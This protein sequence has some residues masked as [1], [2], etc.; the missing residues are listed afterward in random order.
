LRTV[1]LLFL[2]VVIAVIPSAESVHTSS[3]PESIIVVDRFDKPIPAGESLPD[4]YEYR[5]HSNVNP[6]IYTIVPY[7][8]ASD[9]EPPAYP[10]DCVLKAE[11]DSGASLIGKEL[12]VDLNEYPILTWKWKI[13]KIIAKGDAQKKERHDFPA[14]IYVAVKPKGGFNPFASIARTVAKTVKGIPIPK[15]TINLIWSSKYEAGQV[16]TSPWSDTN[17]CVV[18]E[19]GPEHAGQWIEN[20][21]NLL[22]EYNRIFPGGPAEVE[23]V[24]IMTDSD[25]TQSTALAYYDNVVFRKAEE[26]KPI[27][28][29]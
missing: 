25:N 28:T 18:V 21:V 29:Q 20:S 23:G 8:E 9:G 4:W 10:G 5:F 24:G 12:K 16:F 19:G 17:H 14:R 22:E 11:A 2:T 3:N 1:S 26:D 27:E 15:A 13:D 7:E 6:T